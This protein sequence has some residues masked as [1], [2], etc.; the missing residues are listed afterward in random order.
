MGQ[1]LQAL[2]ASSS[3]ESA[4]VMAQEGTGHMADVGD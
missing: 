3:H 4:T 1:I 2:Q